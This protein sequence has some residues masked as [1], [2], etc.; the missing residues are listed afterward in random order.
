[1]RLERKGFYMKRI[2][3][4]KS[5]W[6][7]KQMTPVKVLDGNVINALSSEDQSGEE[8]WIAADMPSQVHDI[9]TDAGVIED[10][11]KPEKVKECVWVAEQ[12]WIYKCSFAG[13]NPEMNKI[14]IHFK[15]LDTLVDIYLNHVLIGKSNDLYLPVRI[16]ITDKIKE[17]NILLLHF[18]SPYK[19]LENYAMPDEWRRTIPS[20]RVI[21]KCENDFIDYLGPKPYFTK[22]GIYDKVQLEFVDTVEIDYVDIAYSLTDDFKKAR[23]QVDVDLTGKSY[24]HTIRIEVKTQHNKTVAQ[25]SRMIECGCKS[26]SQSEKRHEIFNMELADP[27]LWW[28]IGYGEQP[29]YEVQVS[30][31]ESG[32]I[33]DMASKRIGIRTL[34]MVG[35]FDYK[36]NGM[37]I[38][39]WGANFT[40]VNG[41]THC[42][43]EDRIRKILFMAE[44]C[45]MNTLRVWGGGERYDDVLYDIADEKGILLWQEFFNDNGM[46]PDSQEYRN[47]CRKEAEFQ[48]KRLKHH[49]SIL[50]WCGG[51][52]NYMGRDFLFPGE[53][54]IG[55]EIFDVDYREV[56]AS[57]DPGRYYHVSSPYGGAFANDPSTG[58]THSYTNTW[59]VPG[60]DYPVMVS[61]NLRTSIPKLSSLKRFVD[62]NKLWPSDYT[63]LL[64]YGDEYPWPVG[65]T[66]VTTAD[67]WKKIAQIE[68]FYDAANIE[69]AIYR[70]GA[71]YALYLRENVE[72][73]R[74]GKPW[75]NSFGDRICKGHLVWKLNST[76][77]HIYSN[78]IDYYLEPYI[79]Y[80][81]L[82]R[83]YEPFLLSF[84]V[85]DFV[86][87][88]AVN[89]TPDEVRGTVRIGLFNPRQNVIVKEFEIRSSLMPGESGII[90]ELNRFGQFS[91]DNILF[92][93]FINEKGEF[94]ARTNDYVDIER[95]LQF[96]EAK[97]S[98]EIKQG[99]LTITTDQFAR[100]VELTG[101]NDGDD[102]GWIFEDNYFDLLPGENKKVK[103]FTEQPS[104]SIKAKAHFSNNV[105]QIGFR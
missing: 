14:F 4:L 11:C 33:K 34:E 20:W 103:L 95:H 13:S 79:P 35:L 101:S 77:P 28:P 48:V 32:N 39:L 83:A 92:A 46:Q 59:Y 86:H 76:W 87:L 12:D 62:E 91:R 97:L 100:C 2:C 82:K 63:G 22:I 75:W 54:Y 84:D 70:F 29:L 50:L 80:Y 55:K 37:R 25:S 1:M 90:S 16:E 49:P 66:E 10:P 60:A 7:I 36:V 104:G 57:L 24:G 19:F 30:V 43:D 68:K 69:E 53:N 51:N 81:A 8:V 38:K 74:R 17:S 5:S 26:G 9:L 89:D 3:E 15:G 64:K 67:S 27:E 71:A 105:A 96:P 58:D 102:F 72:R 6:S 21:R 47:L 23:M 41:T 94:I 44:N 88:W 31:E 93:Y 56:S 99:V 45:N 98:L 78:V 18:H 52:E 40:Q 65:W 61:E 85:G 42:A 73:Y